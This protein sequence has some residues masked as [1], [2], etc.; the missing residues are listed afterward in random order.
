MSN[1]KGITQFPVRSI[2]AQTGYPAK[3]R[4]KAVAKA[5]NVAQIKIILMGKTS[6]KKATS[7][8]REPMMGSKAEAVAVLNPKDV[9]K[10]IH[11]ALPCKATNPCPK[12]TPKAPILNIVLRIT[13]LL[14]I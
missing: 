9:S 11:D 14:A 10:G 8:S 6:N 4:A 1:A 7:I 5:Q 3:G 13:V 12:N 2:K